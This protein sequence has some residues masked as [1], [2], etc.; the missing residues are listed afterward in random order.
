MI[1]RRHFLA[2]STGLAG[3]MPAAGNTGSSAIPETHFP[4]R[5][6]EFVWRNW[7]LA[8]TGRMAEVV[9]TSPA[10]ILRLGS[11]MELPPK[12]L[13]RPDQLR[14]IYI[15]TIRQNWHL[16]PDAQIVQLL[17]WNR[18]R[19]E[20]TLREDDFLQIKLSLR[21]PDCAELVY[22][23]PASDEQRAAARLAA[24]IKET[25]GSEIRLRGEEPF[26]FVARLSAPLGRPPRPAPA[27]TKERWTTRYLYSHFALYG[28]P[29]MEPDLD[30]FP[31]GYLERLADCGINGVWMQA[32]L[33]TLA[34]S[35]HFP[36]FGQGSE[37]RL[38]NLRRLVERARKAGVKVY[39][40][41]NE[42]R[43]MPEAF[44][45]RH[46]DL[47]GSQSHGFYAMCTSA[48]AVR[49]WIASSLEHVFQQAPALG[50][51]FSITMSENLTN[52]F[53]HSNAWAKAMPVASGCPRCSQRA[54]WDTIA[55][56]LNTFRD[57]VRRSSA[58][59][60]IIAYDW[61]WG[62]GLAEKLIPLLASDTKLLSISEWHA[63]VER[64]GVRTH[65]GEYSISVVG[66]GPR[67]TRNWELA[68]RRGLQTLAKTQFN[69][70]WEISAVPY[71]PVPGL[72]VDHCLNLSRAGIAGVM[73]SWTC[74]GYPS[75]NL[76]AAQAV[77]RDPHPSKVEIL[78]DL[79][80]RRYGAP[81]A[82]GAV[83]AW[84]Q[85]AR[86][87][88]EFPYGVAIYTIPTQHGPANLLRLKPTG[89]RAC[90]ILFPHDDLK[91]WCG[92]YQAEVVLSQFRKMADAWKHGLT[93][94]ERALHGLR[95]A[96]QEDLAV[97][98]TCYNH[99]ASVANQV[100][101]YLLRPKLGTEPVA[102]AMREIARREIAL[103]VDQYRIARRHSVIAYEASNHYY[104][105][106]LD[107]VEKIFNCRQIIEELNRYESS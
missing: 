62:E 19:Y 64:G 103:A 55:E 97:A 67:A 95:G 107:L 85:F 78:A 65:V 2:A 53:S 70:T 37:T 45:A 99:F 35:K 83:Q 68:S 5:L 10:N 58:T 105:R 18:E 42:P 106:P 39:L 21:K 7:E 14:R 49:D 59:A 47:R 89:H 81:A 46:P 90:M 8:N 50:G 52:C 22:H 69:N 98:R 76:D 12:P 100:E 54:S 30:P 24:I 6:H 63:P 77:Y 84:E 86:A 26:D 28:D 9:G 93:V 80:R 92:A 40:Y 102:R 66:P 57:G 31:D 74:G 20:F 25:L 34:P 94:L 1:A 87:F 13:L 11:S 33:H 3:I 60:E 72:I 41:L 91:G 88:Q 56:L 73:A 48:P 44:F 23:Q 36:E 16:L 29:L 43:S 38:A 96:A 101:F 32:V 27:G 82:N 75:L 51:I 15:T 104:Y 4:T 79:A 71:I 61:G 17:G